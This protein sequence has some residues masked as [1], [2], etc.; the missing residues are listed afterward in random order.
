MAAPQEPQDR[1]D[2]I[3]DQDPFQLL[4]ELVQS[5]DS[6]PVRPSDFGPYQILGDAPLGSGAMGDVWLAEEP[7][8]DRRVAVK[9]LRGIA[10]PAQWARREIS[11]LGTLEHQ[12]IARLYN[13]GVDEHGVPWLAMQYV[14]GERLD[15]YWAAKL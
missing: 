5:A 2:W 3:F 4:E 15:N 8:A 12:N 1:L 10:D 14:E 13:H 7:K 6:Q 11:R 9:M